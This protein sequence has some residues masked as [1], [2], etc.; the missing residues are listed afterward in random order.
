MRPN[1]YYRETWWRH[2]MEPFCALLTICAGNSPVTGEF[3]AHKDQWSRTLMSSLICAL[4]KLLSK[5]SW[6]WWFETPS[7]SLWRH[8]NELVKY[9]AWWCPGHSWLYMSS[10]R[11]YPDSK[12]SGAK[13]G[14][15]WGRQDPGG[16]HVGPM[17]FAI[18][19]ATSLLSYNSWHSLWIHV[20]RLYQINFE[21]Q[22]EI[23]SIYTFVL[24]NI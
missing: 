21:E 7:R 12:V 5:Q 15:I 1:D 14:P 23:G 2:Q 19:V 17:N 3:P 13:M 4:N 11:E 24:N 20:K 16:P 9:Y 6:G 8:C 22:N 18:W 10:D